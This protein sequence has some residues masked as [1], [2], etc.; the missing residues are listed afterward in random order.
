MTIRLSISS[1]SHKRNFYS[2]DLVGELT[3]KAIA[4]FP[5]Q[6]ILLGEKVRVL[7]K[8]LTPEKKTSLVIN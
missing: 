8:D 2:E 7:P 5:C 4:Y 6:E 1:S 3:N